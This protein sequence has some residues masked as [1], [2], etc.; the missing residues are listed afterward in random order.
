M[1]GGD[2]ID[3]QHGA[4]HGIDGW[5]QFGKVMLSG[6]EMLGPAAGAEQWNHDI[7]FFERDHLGP[8]GLDLATALMTGNG[9]WMRGTSVIA[10]D[11][12]QVGRIHRR[13]THPHAHLM[14]GKFRQR[15]LDQLKHLSWISSNR[16]GQAKGHA[17]R[18]AQDSEKPIARVT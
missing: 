18:L 9:G 2:G 14:A 13:I 7:P 4:L 16:E 11:E 1:P 15:V 17:T 12:I 3:P 8:H 5:R 6:G 10:L